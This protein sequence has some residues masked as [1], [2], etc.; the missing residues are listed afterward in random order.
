MDSLRKGG[1]QQSSRRSEFSPIESEVSTKCSEVW[2]S[3]VFCDY[4][5]APFIIGYNERE[6]IAGEWTQSIPKCA[7]LYTGKYDY[8]YTVNGNA[9]NI[10][11]ENSARIS[12]IVV[13]VSSIEPIEVVNIKNIPSPEC[14]VAN[15]TFKDKIPLH[16]PKRYSTLF[17]C[18]TK[19]VDFR[20]HPNVS[21]ILITFSEKFRNCELLSCPAIVEFIELYEAINDE[22]FKPDVPAFGKIVALKDR[23]STMKYKYQ[24]QDFFI[25]EERRASEIVCTPYEEW[26]LKKLPKCVP[27]I[28]CKVEP[29][30][31]L[32]V[33]FNWLW[34]ESEAVVGSVA[35]FEC[36]DNNTKING[37]TK[38]ECGSDGEWSEL[39]PQCL[40]HL[41]TTTVET[42]TELTTTL[43]TTLNP[44]PYSKHKEN[45]TPEPTVHSNP[46][47]SP[48]VIKEIQSTTGVSYINSDQTIDNSL[49]SI[50]FV[51]IFL[52]LLLGILIT[53]SVIYLIHK[54]R[55]SSR[56]IES[57][58]N[59]Q[60]RGAHNN[61]RP[62]DDLFYDHIN[63]PLNENQLSNHCLN[64][65]LDS[66]QCTISPYDSSG[67]IQI[68]AVESTR[69]NTF[70]K[71]ENYETNN[72][73]K[74]IKPLWDVLNVN[75]FYGLY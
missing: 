32:K 70:R 67:Y 74:Q 15:S 57:Q 31:E 20:T 36:P 19:D 13:K 30:D 68:E 59:Q 69:M 16:L 21:W 9:V 62:R 60:L 33:T 38:R 46:Y 53:I 43:T 6:C 27:N 45:Q 7:T 23:A 1:K 72:S 37:S 8:N 65:G 10:S 50:Q 49:N 17:H 14:F 55:K 2:V 66:N 63:C 39:L 51:Y 58:S 29:L 42:T 28:T 34:S 44:Y 61:H 35:S 25:M 24:C 47:P 18:P 73:R 56:R 5:D 11:L 64:E 75:H 40:P 71:Y 3:V 22:C 12:G 52:G 4:N 48:P 26:S 41:T 54:R